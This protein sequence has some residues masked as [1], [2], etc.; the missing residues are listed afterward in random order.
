ME[1]LSGSNL[2]NVGELSSHLLDLIASRVGF[3]LTQI[4]SSET[5]RIN[6]VSDTKGLH[7]T[8]FL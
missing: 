6:V 8:L 5:R 1:T 2:V 3:L 4:A 7:R